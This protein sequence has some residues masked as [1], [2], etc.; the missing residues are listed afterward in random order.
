MEKAVMNGKQVELLLVSTEI[1][2]LQ[3]LHYNGCVSLELIGLGIF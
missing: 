2:L 3:Q 1:I